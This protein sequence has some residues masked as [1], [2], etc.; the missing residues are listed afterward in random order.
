M[1]DG[2]SGIVKS[3]MRVI[4]DFC[5]ISRGRPRGAKTDDG[6]PATQTDIGDLNQ[7]LYSHICDNVY[8]L[9][10]DGAVDEQTV[11]Q[12]FCRDDVSVRFRNRV[13]IVKD[14]THA[15]Q[16]FQTH[17]TNTH[18]WNVGVVA[19][20]LTEMLKF[21]TSNLMGC[22][23]LQ[24][25]HINGL[26]TST[27][28]TNIWFTI[29]YPFLFGYHHVACNSQLSTTHQHKSVYTQFSQPNDLFNQ[30]INSINIYKS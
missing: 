1:G 23:H 30:S 16:R 26:H 8:V 24:I 12:E 5:C 18:V 3:I 6:E 20:L 4:S 9:N 21:E 7:Q 28:C 29:Q 2:A 17:S 10:A 19:N 15:M 11:V 25:A 27:G 22:T 14:N 13:L